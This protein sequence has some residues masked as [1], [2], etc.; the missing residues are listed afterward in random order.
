[1]KNNLQKL[2]KDKLNHLWVER[3]LNEVALIIKNE[4]CIGNLSPQET[5][6]SLA[7][8]VAIIQAEYEITERDL[9]VRDKSLPQHFL[10]IIN[11]L[12]LKLDRIKKS[13]GYFAKEPVMAWVHFF[14]DALL[15][16][17]KNKKPVQ[18][19]IKT[20]IPPLA[21]GYDINTPPTA[22]PISI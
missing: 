7:I 15:H 1:M 14:L 19:D 18:P 12:V 16:K 17:A 6:E 20:K 22:P 13:W 4:G 10:Q 11:A 3:Q 2:V 9:K 5:K 8:P 21:L